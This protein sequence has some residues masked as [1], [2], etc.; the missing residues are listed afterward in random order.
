MTGTPARRRL[1][2]NL[3]LAIAVIAS[4][5]L[6]QM[7]RAQQTD[8]SQQ[9][10]LFNSLPPDQQQAILQRLGQG[11]GSGFG[12]GMGMGAGGA[13]SLSGIG[14]SYNSSQ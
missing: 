5:A 6:P 4:F 9:M 1:G 12:L 13:G 2:L 8:L 3:S 11:M 7:L 10:Q 14:G